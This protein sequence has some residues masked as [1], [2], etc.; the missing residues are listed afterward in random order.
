MS[1]P[2]NERFPV[3]IVF[4]C[5]AVGTNVFRT[6]PKAVVQPSVRKP[7]IHYDVTETRGEMADK[8]WPRLAVVVKL[9]EN[10]CC[11]Q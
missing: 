5:F 8:V 4:N 9:T 1:S 3:L 10:L 11:V 6:K 7:E 2:K